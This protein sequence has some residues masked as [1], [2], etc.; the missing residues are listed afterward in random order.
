MMRGTRPAAARIRPVFTSSFEA[1]YA[2]PTALRNTFSVAAG[3]VTVFFAFYALYLY[4]RR[5]REMEAPKG[6]VRLLV[7]LFALL[8]GGTDRA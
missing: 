1:K 7:L 3:V 6:R 2:K 4:R 5:A 8:G